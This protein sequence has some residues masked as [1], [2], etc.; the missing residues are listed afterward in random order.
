MIALLSESSTLTDRFNRMPTIIL[1]THH[2]FWN[3]DRG[4]RRRISS[5]I[6][7]LESQNFNLHV[8]FLGPLDRQMRELLK[9]RYPG[10]QIHWQRKTFLPE[11]FLLRKVRS[12]FSRRMRRII[13]IRR[14]ASLFPAFRTNRSV[15][16]IDS[17]FCARHRDF[18]A[19]LCKIIQPDAVIIEYITLAFLLDGLD[20]YR[21]QK[22][23]RII[24][25][26]DVMS[27][28]SRRFQQAG[29]QWMEVTVEEEIAILSRFDVIVAI[30]DQERALFQKMLPEK[31]IIRA[32]FGTKICPPKAVWGDPLIIGYIATAN[33]PNR[34]AITS[35]IQEV[36]PCIYQKYGSKVCL[37]ISGKICECLNVGSL[38]GG[39]RLRGYVEDLEVL[40]KQTDLAIN[41]VSF[42]SGLKIKNVE[43]ICHSLPLVTTSIGAE[44]LEQGKGSAFCV[45]DSAA[46][47]YEAL[48]RLID[49]RVYREEVAGAAF[50]FAQKYFS[51]QAVYS[52]LLEAIR[53]QKI[54][55]SSSNLIKV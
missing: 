34:Q 45:G 50:T 21:K 1:A 19:R 35:F 44:G 20:N 42:G 36:W 40:Y 51:D 6:Q 16:G 7:F 33:D 28:R 47:Q 18:F 41:P 8:F 14:I 12:A 31:R 3:N 13:P 32:G 43:A 15:R 53:D 9:I 52:E 26:H 55:P 48:C 37:E 23:L 39:V 54:S 10:V 49:S 29:Y 2:E 4:D 11:Y 30:Q 38:P 46:S 24:D 17:L 25:T 5:L 22:L 27:L